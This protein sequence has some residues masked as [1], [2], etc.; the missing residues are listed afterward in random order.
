MGMKKKVSPHADS[1]A[2]STIQFMNNR[3]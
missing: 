3:Q 1:L 2:I